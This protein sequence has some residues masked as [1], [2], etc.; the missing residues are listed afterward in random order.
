MQ[1]ESLSQIT[2]PVIY[3]VYSTD[4]LT[5]NYIGRYMSLIPSA[6]PTQQMWF[7]ASIMLLYRDV[8]ICI[9]N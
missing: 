2:L 4:T 5:V 6:H 3:T 8:P 9:E 7:S 1:V